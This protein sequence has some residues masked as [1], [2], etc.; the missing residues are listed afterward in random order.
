MLL[1][2][3]SQA[4]EEKTIGGRYDYGE[5]DGWFFYDN[6]NMVMIKTAMNVEIMII[7][8]IMMIWKERMWFAGF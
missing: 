2:Q 7:I 8:M 5:N 1:N 3:I 4:E 6:N